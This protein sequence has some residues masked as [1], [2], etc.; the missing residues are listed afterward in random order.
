MDALGMIAVWLP[1]APG[2]LEKVFL[3]MLVFLVLVVGAFSLYVLVQQFRNP[4]RTPRI[5][6][7]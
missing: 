3:G 5:R 7:R 4:G 6:T 1:E 2:L